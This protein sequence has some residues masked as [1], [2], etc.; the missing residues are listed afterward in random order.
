MRLI[1]LQ[2]ERE[3][4]LRIRRT[5]NT[6]ADVIE[7][8][9]SMLDIEESMLDLASERAEDMSEE[10]VATPTALEGPCS[11]LQTAPADVA[12]T[13]PP[14]VRTACARAR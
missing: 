10:P 12:P 4:V 7:Q 9:L 6:E 13:E 2:A 14:A 1:T 3:E 11:H 5:G 8:V